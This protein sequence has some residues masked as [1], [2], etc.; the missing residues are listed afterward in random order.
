[1]SLTA[2]LIALAQVIGTDVKALV[3]PPINPVKLLGQF[4]YT[5]PTVARPVVPAYISLN[6]VGPAGAGGT[7]PANMAP[8]DTWDLEV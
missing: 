8:G 6:W 1:M 4:Q 3:A 7:A 2:N 5:D